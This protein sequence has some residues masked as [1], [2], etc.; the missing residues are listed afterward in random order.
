MQ[1]CDAAALISIAELKLIVP[2]FVVN[3]NYNA[4]N[5]K[6]QRLVFIV[7]VHQARTQRRQSASIC[8]KLYHI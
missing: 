3:Y 1:L 8:P 2:S 5:P 4:L 6:T 7:L